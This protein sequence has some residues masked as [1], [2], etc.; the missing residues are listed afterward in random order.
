MVEMEEGM[1]GFRQHKTTAQAKGKNLSGIKNQ[2]EKKVNEQRWGRCVGCV[3]RVD[4][5]KLKMTI[6]KKVGGHVRPV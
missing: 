2:H 1:R 5:I 4:V 3:V 6:L